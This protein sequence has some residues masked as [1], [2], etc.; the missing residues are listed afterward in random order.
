M[1]DLLMYLILITGVVGLFYVFYK[2]L[3]GGFKAIT[4]N[5]D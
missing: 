3:S 1:I 5:D 4:N 2:I